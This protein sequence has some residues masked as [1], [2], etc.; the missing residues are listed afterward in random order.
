MNKNKGAIAKL[1]DC[2]KVTAHTTMCNCIKD[3]KRPNK[4]LNNSSGPGFFPIY[5]RNFY[6][7]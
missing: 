4:M 6:S 3:I 7:L 5:M 2:T 1:Y